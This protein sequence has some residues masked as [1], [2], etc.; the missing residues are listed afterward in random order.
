M[1]HCDHGSLHAAIQR[2]IFKPT[3]RWGPKL[4]LRALIRTVRAGAWGGSL[5]WMVAG[6]GS[7]ASEWRRKRIAGAGGRVVGT[8]L[9]GAT[10]EVE[11]LGI[12]A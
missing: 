6:E 1:E 7:W 9:A 2:G 3:S 11:W 4:A 5:M 8:S 10:V 12:A